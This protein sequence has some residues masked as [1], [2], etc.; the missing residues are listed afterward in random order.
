M[1]WERQHFF[2][3]A[4]HAVCLIVFAAASGVSQRHP[5]RRPVAGASETFGVHE[6]FHQVDRVSVRMLPIGAQPRRH[7]TQ[8]VRRQMLDPHPRQ[9]QKARVVG[10]KANVASPRFSA[11]ADEAIAAA[12]VSWRRTPGQTGERASAGPDQIL[13][14]FAD[15]LLVPEIVMLLEQA[16]EQRLN[17]AAPNLLKLDWTEFAQPRGNR[18]LVQ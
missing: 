11:P 18:C 14:L 6:R 17:G 13:Q 5:V 10:E 3:R 15:W 9:Y 2:D 12:E 4:V 8:Q 7:A 1:E 16:V